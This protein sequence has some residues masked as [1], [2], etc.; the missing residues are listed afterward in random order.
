MAATRRIVLLMLL[1]VSNE[2]YATNSVT[3]SDNAESDLTLQL[4]QLVS[5]CT[6][7]S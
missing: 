6:I 7:C 4:V 1:L 2:I 5:I 3:G